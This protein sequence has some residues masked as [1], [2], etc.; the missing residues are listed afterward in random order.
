MGSFNDGEGVSWYDSTDA[1][2]WIGDGVYAILVGGGDVEEVSWFEGEFDGVGSLVFLEGADDEERRLVRLIH[3]AGV[4]DARV[5]CVVAG[6]HGRRDVSWL[7]GG[8]SELNVE[9]CLESP[10]AVR[11]RMSPS[12]E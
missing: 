7:V 2:G 12:S 10:L 8:G 3:R 9:S 5:P 1:A 11:R 4:C 6:G